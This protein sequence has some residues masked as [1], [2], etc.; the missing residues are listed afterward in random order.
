MNF[1]CSDLFKRRS[2][3]CDGASV[4]RGM[5]DIARKFWVLIIASAWILVCPLFSAPAVPDVSTPQ[6][7]RE[8]RSQAQNIG[9]SVS[10]YQD[11]HGNANEG[12]QKLMIR[13]F[14]VTHDLC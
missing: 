3:F 9:R 8:L 5:Q 10:P 1:T 11:M 6:V 13:R 2:K 7:L 4:I 12:L 14:E